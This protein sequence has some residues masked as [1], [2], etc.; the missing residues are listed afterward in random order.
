MAGLQQ[1][2]VIDVPQWKVPVISR[3]KILQQPEIAVSIKVP[4]TEIA[5]MPDKQYKAFSAEF[6]KRFTPQFNRMSGGW[7]ADIQ[8]RM[9]ETEATI[10]KLAKGTGAAFKEKGK[11]LMQQL[12][13]KANAELKA[14]CLKWT[15]KVA[16]IAQAAYDEAVAASLKAMQMKVT[17]AKAKMIAKVTLF[18]LLTLTAAALT[19]A[20][21]VVT[22]GAGAA[23]APLVIAGIVTAGKALFGSAKQ[24]LG[25]YDVLATTVAAVESDTKA[26]SAAALAY[27]KASKKTAG[28]LDQ[29]KLFHKMLSA[30]VAQ[31]DK[32]VGQLDKFTA[33][34]RAQSLQ[35]LKEIQALADQLARAKDQSPEAKAAEQ[36]VLAAQ[37]S[38]DDALEH[39]KS[40]AD[41]KP[42]AEQAREAFKKM[43]AEGIAKA[44]GRMA[45]VVTKIR[46]ASAIAKDYGD[47]LKTIASSVHQ[48]AKG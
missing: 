8:R 20:L 22:A 41:V 6:E 44:L 30:D 16:E 17:K 37:R 29:L 5:E 27:G 35:S 23:V 36:R 38:F 26:L 48:L 34:A 25:S 33:V 46:Q 10:E 32:H 13:D 4:T 1:G 12:V 14:L 3:K 9:D 21:T 18:V 47:S 39:L 42:A 7:F 24:V 2:V 19:I 45:P 15:D 31:L 11:A 40:I 28:K 43:D